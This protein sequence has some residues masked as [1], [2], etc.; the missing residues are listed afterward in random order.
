MT[1][2]KMSTITFGGE[3]I[4]NITDEKS[5]H[6]NKAQTLTEEEKKQARTNIGAV[7]AEEVGKLSEEIED[8]KSDFIYTIGKNK[9]NKNSLDNVDGKYITV[10]DSNEVLVTYSGISCSEKISVKGNDVVVFT[11]SAMSRTNQGIVYCNDGTVIAL[12]SIVTGHSSLYDKAT[13]PQNAESVRFN[14]ETDKKDSVFFGFEEYP[15]NETGY[16]FVPYTK[17][18]RLSTK[19]NFD[20]LNIVVAGDSIMRGHG[21]NNISALEIIGYLYGGNI[22]NKAVS[23]ARLVTDESL[24]DGRT[25]ITDIIINTDFTDV[26][27]LIFDG[28]YNDTAHGKE[29]SVTD[30]YEEDTSHIWDGATACGGLEMIFHYMAINYPNT[31]ILYIFPTAVGTNTWRSDTRFFGNIM[32]VLEKWNIDYIDLYKKSQA[33][34][35]FSNTNALYYYNSDGTHPNELGYKH[36]YVQPISKWI[37]ENQENY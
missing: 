21:N 13:M 34:G 19:Y 17:R 8:V 22:N 23:G 26:D 29:G 36:F 30:F 32:K 4:F 16:I 1:N 2:I 35:R 20:N 15:K 28:G 31:K 3:E 12:S 10:V 37:F 6:F 25:S 18:V 33:V 7:S 9:F 5:V 14:Y 24:L 11:F 27:Y